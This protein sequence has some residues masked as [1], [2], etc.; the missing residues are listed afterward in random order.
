[1][2][3]GVGDYTLC[4]AEALSKEAVDVAVLTDNEACAHEPK[5]KYEVFPVI[6]RWKLP[7]FF[8]IVKIVRQWKPDIIHIQFPTQGYRGSFFPLILP[9]LLFLLRVKIVQTWHEYYSKDHVDW[10]LIP[11]FITPGG[12][13]AV[14]PNYREQMPPLYRFLS[15]HKIFRFIPNASAIPAVRIND[16]E[17]REVHARFTSQN[18]AVLVYF[19]FIYPEKGVE[20]LFDVA[21]PNKHHIVFIGPTDDGDPY[22]KTILEKINQSS[23]HG[24]VTFTGFL[25]EIETARMLAAADAVVLPF[26]RGGGMWNSSLHAAAL[27][28][29]FILTTSQENRGYVEAENIYYARP[30]DVGEMKHALNLY[31]GRKNSDFSSVQYVTWESIAKAHLDLYHSILA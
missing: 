13:V 23:W 25:P 30:G 28:G 7:E 2:K 10:V 29:T 19:G 6:H 9:P 31:V 20:T 3:C 27:Q 24:N 8:K 21:D 18:K 1:M 5:A 15:R 26:R 17:R 11:K 4:L 12:L 22:F 16:T 14:R